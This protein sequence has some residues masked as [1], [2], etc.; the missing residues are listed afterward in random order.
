LALKDNYKPMG[1]YV[2]HGANDDNVNVQFAR[3]MREQLTPFHKDFVYDE[4]EGKG[5]WWGNECMDWPPMLDYLAKH[6]VPE[7]KNVRDV[8][9]V[10]PSIGVT[11]RYHWATIEGQAHPCRLSTLKLHGDPARSTIEGTTENVSRLALDVG[12]VASGS[13]QV[14]LDGQKIANVSP[15]AAGQLLR[16]ARVQERW[17]VA[18]PLPAG[19]KNPQRYGTFKDAWRNRVQLVYG[20]QGNA[21]ENAW[22]FAKAR[23]DAERFWY[24]ANAGL[25][26]I[27]DTAFDPKADVD[28]SVVLYGNADTNAAWKPL[29]ANSPVQVNREAVTC[30]Q[31]TERAHDLACLFVRPRPGSNVALVAVVGG[32]GLGGMTLTQRL[33]YFVSGVNYPD[34]VLLDGASLKDGLRAVRGAGFFGPDWGVAQGEFAWRATP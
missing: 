33:P 12:H 25:D 28:R 4:R 24:T 19:W 32:T 2:L 30:D 9:F 18:E 23:F 34:F 10:T 14:T 22:A 15:P 7:P 11:A 5:H 13:L 6:E 31:R 16:L 1:V 8:E 29:L 3:T 20:T 27:P 21:E 26:V 17:T